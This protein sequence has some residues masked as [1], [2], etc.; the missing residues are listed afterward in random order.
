VNVGTSHDTPDFAVESI[1]L[2]WEQECRTRYPLADSLLVLADSGGSNSARSRLW[3][4][5]LQE[6]A[7]ALQSRS[8]CAIY[9]LAP[10][11]GTRWNTDCSPSSALKI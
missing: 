9:R 1:R 3:K 4:V 11:S 2:W 10:V 8:P 5:R 7:D 6:L